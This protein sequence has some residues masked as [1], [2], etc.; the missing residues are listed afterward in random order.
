MALIV[1][2][3]AAVGAKLITGNDIKNGTITTKDI[4]NGTVSSDDLKNNN[5]KSGD[6][7]DGTVASADIKDGGVATKDLAKGSVGANK[8]A[9]GAVAFPNTL[10]GPMIRN[11]QGAGESTLVTGPAGQPMGAGSLQLKTTVASD[12]AAFGD[13]VDFAGIPLESIT[14]LSYSSFNPDATP[15]VR[16]GPRFEVNPHLADDAN[17]GGV[18]EFTTVAYSPAPGATGW[19]TAANIQNDPRWFATGDAETVTGC[20]QA[21]QCTLTALITALVDHVDADPAPPAISSGVYFALGAGS[22]PATTAVDKFVVNLSNSTHDD[23]FN[24]E[25]NG[26]FLTTP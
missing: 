20:T 1:S 9:P 13:S 23:V 21:S 19:E 24:F 8:L 17:V 2:G 3:G 18:F 6:I 16:P 14:S 12:L 5:V 11:Q 26:V 7:K 25:P 15:L 4:K 22:A 10:W